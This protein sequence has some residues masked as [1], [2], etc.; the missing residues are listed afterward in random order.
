MTQSVPNLPPSAPPAYAME[1]STPTL[2]SYISQSTSYL[3]EVSA[4]PL[5][6]HAMT[7]SVPNL[8][9]SAPVA[10]AMETSTPTFPSSLPE[11]TATP[12]PLNAIDAPTTFVDSNVVVLG[13]DAILLP[14]EDPD[15]FDYSSISPLRPPPAYAPSLVNLSEEMLTS[16]E[17]YDI[18]QNKLQD[19]GWKSLFAQISPDDFG[20]IIGHV[21]MD[22]DQPRVAV[23]L[24]PVV[25]GGDNFSCEYCAAAVR[26][27]S[28]WNRSTIV[29]RLVPHCIDLAFNKHL[30]QSELSEWDQLIT[31]RCITECLARCA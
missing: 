1:S 14:E 31:D 24:A 18:I 9:P 25:N 13:G 23:L 3:P 12:L 26:C 29:E 5:P 17:D 16:V 4:I 7:Q 27:T 10:Y 21:N 6:S 8:P 30:I 11:I 28:E 15:T 2:P 19:Y 20:A 22:F